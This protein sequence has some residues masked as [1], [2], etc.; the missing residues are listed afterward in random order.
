MVE[1]APHQFRVEHDVAD[2]TA[3]AAHRL[4]LADPHVVESHVGIELH[5]EPLHPADQFIKLVDPDHEPAGIRKGL[6][7]YILNGPVVGVDGNDPF[8]AIEIRSFS[9]PEG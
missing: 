5:R 4:V 2:V 1:F 8:H 7:R 9:W 6:G 3:A